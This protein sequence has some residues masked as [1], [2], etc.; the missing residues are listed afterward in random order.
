VRDD[1]GLKPDLPARDDVGL[2]P[3]L[4]VRDDVGLKRDLPVRDDVGLK[5]DLPVRDDVGLK[6]GLPARRVAL[7]GLLFGLLLVLVWLPL[8]ARAGLPDTIARIKPSVVAVGTYQTTRRPPSVFRGTGFVVG[9]GRY[10]ATNNHVLPEVLDEANRE[11]LAVFAG[12]GTT[13][14]VR[15]AKVVARDPDHDL[16]LLEI[17]GAPLKPLRLAEGAVREG[18][19]VAFTGFPVGMVLGLYHATH[20]GII[21]AVSPLAIPALGG[22]DLSP[23]AIKAMREPFDVYQLDATAYPGNSGSPLYDPDTGDVI[24]VINSVFVKRTKEAVLTDPSGIT[25]AIP[26]KFLRT[27]LARGR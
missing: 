24:G 14:D 26:V 12:H 4:P 1:V 9:D 23:Q 11:R 18:Q 20:R 7:V 2:K 3:D 15:T 6:A 17:A 16:A 10:V 25:Y 8:P 5:P 21:A 19:D 22:K 13:Q 27:L